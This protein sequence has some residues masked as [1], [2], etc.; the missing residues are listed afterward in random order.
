MV[1]NYKTVP[2]TR[3]NKLVF[4]SPNEKNGFHAYQNYFGVFGIAQGTDLEILRRP[5]SSPVGDPWV[6]KN[7]G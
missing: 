1:V 2:L 3:N 7:I 6:L 5:S 4:L